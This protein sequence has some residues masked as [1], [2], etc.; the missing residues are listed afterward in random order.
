MAENIETFNAIVGLIFDQLYRAFPVDVDIDVEH[1]AKTLGY[2]EPILNMGRAGGYAGYDTG[3]LPDGT[4][5]NEFVSA[6]ADWLKSEGFVRTNPHDPLVSVILTA[7]ALAALNASPSS[8]EPKLGSKLAGAVKAAGTETGRA[9]IGET[10]GQIIGA[11]VKSV[12]T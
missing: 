11:V 9:A 8:L 2:G 7:K 12:I 4:S 6:A 3:R 10:V 5:V 1:I